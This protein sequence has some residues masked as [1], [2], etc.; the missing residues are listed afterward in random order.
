MCSYIY[1]LA[2]H[3]CFILCLFKL[4]KLLKATRKGKNFKT[5]IL[6][7]ILESNSGSLTQ[8]GSEISYA[9]THDLSNSLQLLLQN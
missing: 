9:L 2:L 3:Q 7:H 1:S 5:R 4:I 6:G 8:K